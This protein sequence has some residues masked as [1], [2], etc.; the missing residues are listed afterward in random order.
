MPVGRVKTEAAR[1][2]AGEPSAPAH[3]AHTRLLKRILPDTEAL[4]REV[5]L[6]IQRTRGMLVVDDTTDKPYTRKMGLVTRH[7]SKKH[8]RA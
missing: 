6:F 5:A 7:W 8:R 3:D 2:R 1:V 4:W